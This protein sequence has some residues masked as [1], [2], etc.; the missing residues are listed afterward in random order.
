M[1]YAQ[2]AVGYHNAE[3]FEQTLLQYKDSGASPDMA[4][5]GHLL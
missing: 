3:F 5:L 1:L 2:A 4:V